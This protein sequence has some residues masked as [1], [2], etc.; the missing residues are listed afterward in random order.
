M[1][2]FGSLIEKFKQRD[3]RLCFF[4][5]R[6]SRIF[7]IIHDINMYT[8]LYCLFVRLSRTWIGLDKFTELAWILFHTKRLFHF[9]FLL[10]LN[11]EFWDLC[12]A[13]LSE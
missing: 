13:A 9:V 1:I 8:L 3:N 5:N 11:L 12:N 2:S 4:H 10:Y 7:V 6:L